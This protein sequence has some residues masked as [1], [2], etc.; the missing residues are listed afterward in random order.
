MALNREQLTVIN[1]LSENIMLLASAGTGKTETLA[2][3]VANIIETK[4]APGDEILCITFTNKACKEMK[5]RVEQIVGAEGNKVKVSTF[6]SFCF[7]IIKQQ[8]KKRTDIFTDFVV[9]DEDDCIEIIKTCNYF[10]FPIPLIQRFLDFIK[11]ERA[12][13]DIYSEDEKKDY[14]E[15]VKLSF[16]ENEEKINSLCSDRGNINLNLNLKKFLKEKGHI[17]INSYNGTLR[18]NHAVDF[19]DIIVSVKELFKDEQLIETLKIKYKYINIDE[20]QDTSLLEYSIIEKIFAN[21]NILICGDIFQ[22]IYKWRG[23]EPDKIFD[24]FKNKY[25][26]KEIIF[27][28]NYRAT[29]NLTEASLSYL[30]N[31]FENEVNEIYK[32]E[33]K[34]FTEAEGEKIK[35]KALN[36]SMEEARFIV[37]EIRRLQ[38]KGE[39]LNKIAVLTRNN[40]YN[41][42]L[43]RNIENILSREGA[44]FSFALVDQFR[45]FRRQEIKDII[46]FLKIIGNKND[47]ISLK[48]IVKRLPTGVGDKAFEAI[49]SDEY[50]SI[51]ISLCDYIDENTVLFGE[52]YGLLINEFENN[53]IIVFDVESTGVDVTEDEIIQIAAIK[54]NKYGEVTEKFEKF[55]KNKKSVKSSEHVHGFSDK[56]LRENGED[57][58]V[59]LK[60]FIEFSK[61][62]II[63]GH[64][65]QFD[66]NILTSELSRL[67]LG[68]V[69]FKGFFDTLD[70]YK[71]FYSNL[72]NHKLDTLSRIFETV[73]K[74]SHDA[75]D[76]ILATKELL[77]MAIKNKIKPTSLERIAHMSKHM[78]AFTAIRNKLN[79]LF[80]KA[81][82]LRPCDIVAEVINGFSIKTLY[83]GEEG[84]EKIERLRD[85]YMLLKELDEE[86]KSNRDA[87]MEIIK[88]TAL[89][90]GDLEALI[91]NRSK[92]PKIPIIT[93]HQSKGLEY[94]TVF[95]AGL[96]ENTFPSYMSVKANNI[97]E[98]KRTFYVAI[99]R[100][101]KRL[102]MTCSLEGAYGRRGEESRFIKLID[103]KYL[104]N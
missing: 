57:K 19:A 45:F 16:K 70:I 8:A 20:V 83:P 88:I 71:R 32:E 52:K 102:Y 53:N 35:Y 44:D 64:N 62:A 17:L 79:A 72:P 36:S 85:F 54:I 65:V 101:K 68:K 41:V 80:I 67:N 93:V 73:N 48:R 22:T 37:D 42:E 96:K 34:A 11:L 89:S 30:K 95:L 6:H 104:S 99:T 76:D 90:N 26:P 87:L 24:K 10:N 56:F 27:V 63:V 49:E 14:E 60:E 86:E 55:L 3:R 74:P 75:M 29:K 103:D 5:E 94:D 43:S 25:K 7:D 13:R 59:V 12:R 82:S 31:A 50:K 92:F 38:A 61:D 40:R 98:E 15:V 100:A 33:I 46:A 1:E 28:K 47:A 58:E 39:D 78:K 2:R 69:K 4:K 77:V 51:G 97:D 9:F 21:N 23:S 18:N 66:I 84:R 81:E 91:I